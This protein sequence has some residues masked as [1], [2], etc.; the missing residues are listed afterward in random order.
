MPFMPD[1]TEMFKE[2]GKMSISADCD[3]REP[4]ISLF[5]HV[6]SRTRK[7]VISAVFEEKPVMHDKI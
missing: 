2:L 1:K 3:G 5:L 6:Q 7:L 4:I